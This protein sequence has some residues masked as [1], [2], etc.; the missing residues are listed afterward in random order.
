MIS[1]IAFGL[2]GLAVLISVAYAFS[3]RKKSVDWM[4]V[5]AGIGLQIAFA[6]VVIMVPGGS[7]WITDLVTQE[8][9]KVDALVWR[10]YADYLRHCC[11]HGA[12]RARVF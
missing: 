4:Q 1:T 8:H 11:H 10:R 7:I 2:F 5:F 9:D 3:T 12:R 6:I